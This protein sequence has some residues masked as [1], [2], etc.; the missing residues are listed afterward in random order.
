MALRISRNGAED[1]PKWRLG[2]L[3]AD[4]IQTL[5]ALMIS[6]LGADDIPKWR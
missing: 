5:V 6:G 3:G 1:N 2:R 4:D